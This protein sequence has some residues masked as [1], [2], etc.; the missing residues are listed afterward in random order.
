MRIPIPLTA[1]VFVC[2]CHQSPV[3]DDSLTS[4]ARMAEI[5][6]QLGIQYLMQGEYET[7]LSRLNKALKA[8]SNYV[9]AYNALGLLYSTLGQ[10]DEADRNFK[11]AIRLDPKN[12]LALNNYG[13]FLCQQGKVE[14]GLDK[15][16]KAVQNPLY[17]SPA[18]ALTNAGTCVQNGGD[19]ERAETYF[20]RALEI[21]AR[22]AP[23]LIQMANLTYDSGRFLPARG[24]LQRY[25]EVAAHTSK[26]LWLAIHIERDLGDRDTEA[27]YALRLEKSFP[28]SPEARLLQEAQQQ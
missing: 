7:A 10:I 17:K 6:T 18:I 15:F 16:S 28:D 27:S 14:E 5:N 1:L 4:P 19:S 9:D 21:D 20:R 22:V 23:A 11:R 8:D 24:Y 3:N 26:S 13:Q 12:S 2:G 25:Q